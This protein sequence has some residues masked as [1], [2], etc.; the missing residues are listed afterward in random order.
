LLRIFIN[1]F[2]GA[3]WL[4]ISLL[5]NYILKENQ[6]QLILKQAPNLQK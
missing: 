2:K 3:F 5:Y 4:V 6:V 1:V